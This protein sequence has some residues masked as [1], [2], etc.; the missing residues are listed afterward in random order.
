MISTPLRL[1]RALAWIIGGVTPALEL[2]RRWHEVTTMTVYWPSLL[3]DFTVGKTYDYTI[4]VKNSGKTV[5]SFRFLSGVEEIFAVDVVQ[6]FVNPAVGGAHHG[7]QQNE[8]WIVPSE[9]A[10]DRLL[11][12]GKTVTPKTVGTGPS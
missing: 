5:A 12:P 6:G 2:A 10:V 7:D 4:T 3:D 1:S 9:A 11:G 8:I